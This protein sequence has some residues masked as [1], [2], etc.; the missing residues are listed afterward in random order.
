MQNPAP[1][2]ATVASHDT[3]LNI[4]V[5]RGHSTRLQG[6]SMRPYSSLICA[7]SMI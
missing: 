6:G 5:M 2:T 3:G 7:C 1:N 4:R